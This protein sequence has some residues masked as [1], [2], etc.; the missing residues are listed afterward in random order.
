MLVRLFRSSRK[1][2]D[3]FSSD[4]RF[5]I[6]NELSLS[7]VIFIASGALSFL[8]APLFSL[9]LIPFAHRVGAIDVPRDARRMHSHPKARIGGVAI[10]ISFLLGYGLFLR[11]GKGLFTDGTERL[12]RCLIFG[13]G[14]IV[15]GG[16]L[17]DRRGL[18]PW[19]K[20]FF[21]AFAS[22]VAVSFG[23]RLWNG[24]WGALGF[25]L[26][27]ILLSNAFNLID[28]LD[29]LASRVSA[30]CLLSI[31]MISGYEPT[32]VILLAALL[33]FVPLNIH[34]SRLFLG[35]A[36]A[37]LLGFSLSVCSADV[38]ASE[39]STS[40]FASILLI[41]A[42][43][44]F[45]TA[46]AAL[47]RT[48]RGK[49]PF[50]PDREHLHHKL[51]DGGMSHSQASLLLSLIGGSFASVGALVFSLGLTSIFFILLSLLI[52]VAASVI[53]ISTKRSRSDKK[54]G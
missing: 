16:F 9:I 8:S 35:D 5:L 4:R 50:S 51:V 36:G 6:L 27:S 7:T 12:A 40:S 37:M 31:L 52:F 38:F 46:S 26:W 1:S 54:D 39:P 29:G 23:A 49:S 47:R 25:I 3:S 44:I 21:Q 14:V 20:I 32:L 10:F 53:I 42:L 43:P 2:L 34:P 45:D 19:Q 13:G 15:L 33:G 28:G 41:F 18:S 24:F 22:I 48:L 11:F 17:D 30:F